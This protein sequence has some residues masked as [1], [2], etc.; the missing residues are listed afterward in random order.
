MKR[1][2]RGAI[3]YL[4][5]V[6]PKAFTEVKNGDDNSVLIEEMEIDNKPY[7]VLYNTKTGNMIYYYTSDKIQ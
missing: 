5:R 6:N 3:E 1:D 2:I 7:Q 4:K